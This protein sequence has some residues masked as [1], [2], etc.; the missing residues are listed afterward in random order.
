MLF[1]SEFAIEYLAPRFHD[2]LDF[3]R[4]VGHHARSRRLV[5]DRSVEVPMAAEHVGRVFR[6]AE[7]VQFLQSSGYAIHYRSGN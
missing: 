1:R 4:L 2:G 3:T 6:E 7:F 5:A